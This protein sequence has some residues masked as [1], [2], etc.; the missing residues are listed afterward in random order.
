MATTPTFQP[1]D[2]LRGGSASIGDARRQDGSAIA[3]GNGGDSVMDGE[4]AAGLQ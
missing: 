1:A 4:M 2:A 3:M